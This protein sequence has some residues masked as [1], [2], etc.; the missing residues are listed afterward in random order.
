MKTYPTYILLFTILFVSGCASNKSDEKDSESSPEL[1]TPISVGSILT[2]LEVMKHENIEL[3][4]NQIQA[5]VI[6]VMGYGANTDIIGKD[7]VLTLNFR[8]SEAFSS[9][10]NIKAGETFKALITKAPPTLNSTS[11]SSVY[12][13][14]ELKK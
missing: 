2:N 12:R 5:K 4:E 14:I 1:Q 6:E 11:S 3:S 9:L 7:A 13:I 8:D 10:K